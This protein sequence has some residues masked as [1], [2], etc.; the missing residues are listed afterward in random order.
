MKWYPR[1]PSAAIA[2][3]IGLSAEE[4]GYYNLVIDLQ[5]ARAP[6]ADV[7]DELVIKAMGERPQVWR[8]VKA[9]LIGKGKIREVDG[10]LC[11][12]RVETE[13]KLAA[14]RIDKHIVLGDQNKEKQRVSATRARAT[15]TSISI[16]PLPPSATD[17]LASAPDGALARP[18][19]EQTTSYTPSG[20][21]P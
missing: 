9:S 19:F 16:T 7:K 15:S 5:Y 4:R 1:D 10:N 20:M 14:K 2:G 8:R 12:N 21:S 17:A 11:A 6:H 3:M 18:T 13:L